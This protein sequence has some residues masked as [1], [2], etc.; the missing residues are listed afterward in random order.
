MSFSPVLPEGGIHIPGLFREK[1]SIR[2]SPESAQGDTSTSNINTLIHALIN[3]GLKRP[4]DRKARNLKE[5]MQ[6]DVSH[7][8]GIV[9]VTAETR[10]RVAFSSILVSRWPSH[11]C[12]LGFSSAK[13]RY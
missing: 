2:A 8:H 6:F 3:H 10:F 13:S 5:G 11:W 7:R 1:S 9:L 12:Y 4:P